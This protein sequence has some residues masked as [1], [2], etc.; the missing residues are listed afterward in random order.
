MSLQQVVHVVGKWIVLG[1][2]KVIY[3]PIL[4][5]HSTRVSH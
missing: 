3:R 1:N 5:V 2:N 4:P